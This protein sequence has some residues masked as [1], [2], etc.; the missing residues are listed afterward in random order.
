MVKVSARTATDFQDIFLKRGR[1]YFYKKVFS[2]AE[3]ALNDKESDI[4]LL[5]QAE[6]FFSLFRSTGNKNMFEIAKILRRV[7][8][9]VYRMKVKRDPS[10]KNSKFL[11]LVSSSA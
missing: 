1:D 4:I 6:A 2:S 11:Q 8:H 10:K 9:K 3:Q 7:A 5:E